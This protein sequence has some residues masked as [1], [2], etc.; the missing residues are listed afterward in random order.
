[1]GVRRAS[2][3]YHDLASKE[4]TTSRDVTVTYVVHVAHLAPVLDM[5]KTSSFLGIGF[6]SWQDRRRTPG[7]DGSQQDQEIW[8]YPV[9]SGQTTPHTPAVLPSGGRWTFPSWSHSNSI[10]V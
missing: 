3:C 7:S 10:C 8:V 9:G 5:E 4:A 1:M 6:T 2:D